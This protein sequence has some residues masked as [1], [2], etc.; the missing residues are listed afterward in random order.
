MA[1]YRFPV[2]VWQ[3]HE[4]FF[5]ACL[6]DR[7]DAVA[8]LGRT[9]ADAREQLRDYLVWFYRKNP[10]EAGPAFE[11][12]LREW[13]ATDNVLADFARR[14][15]SASRNASSSIQVTLDYLFSVLNIALATFLVVKV[16]GNRTANLLAVGMVAAPSR[17]STSAGASLR[18][19]ISPAS[20]A[21]PRVVLNVAPSILTS[22]K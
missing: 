5:T 6:A 21:R 11:D 16:R 3:D 17:V 12:Q 18:Y 4:G 9:A 13:G 14:A 10:W 19:D 15:A 2:L 8:G 1:T 20:V 7:D 22:S